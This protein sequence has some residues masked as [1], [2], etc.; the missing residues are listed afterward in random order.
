MTKSKKQ[1]GFVNKLQKEKCTN[2]VYELQNGKEI[3]C[4]LKSVAQLQYSLVINS[5]PIERDIKNE[6]LSFGNLLCQKDREKDIS[7]FNNGIVGIKV[8]QNERI[9]LNVLAT[10]ISNSNFQLDI[11]N[12]DVDLS[13]VSFRFSKNIIRKLSGILDTKTVLRNLGRIFIFKT[14]NRG[15][16]YVVDRLF[17]CIDKGDC[18]EFKFAKYLAYDYGNKS[19]KGYAKR[20]GFYSKKRHTIYETLFLELLFGKTAVFKDKKAPSEF[21]IK[22]K[23]LL[24][25]INLYNLMHENKKR[26]VALLNEFFKAAF[27]FGV[28][29]GEAPVF[30]TKTLNRDDKTKITLTINPDFDWTNCDWNKWNIKK[31]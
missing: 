15:G 3:D 11:K 29:I 25:N 14:N 2:K 19:D 7:E 23:T 31:I 5:I 17:L 6:S 28:F 20:R 13:K 1:K 12:K 22:T 8:S 24:E 26:A 18:Y 9:M 10:L 4:L 30:K 27:E 21:E 16:N